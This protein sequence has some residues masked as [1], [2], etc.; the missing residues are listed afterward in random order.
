MLIFIYSDFSS[1]FEEIIDSI[2][3]NHCV[4]TTKDPA[5]ANIALILMER[6]IKKITEFLDRYPDLSILTTMIPH[7]FEDKRVYFLNSRMRD[8]HVNCFV[9]YLWQLKNK[10]SHINMKLCYSKLNLKTEVMEAISVVSMLV[11]IDSINFSISFNK[12]AVYVSGYDTKRNIT[13]SC[14]VNNGGNDFYEEMEVITIYGE[15]YKLTG[16]DELGPHSYGERYCA[17]W[18]T[19]LNEVFQKNGYYQENNDLIILKVKGSFRNF[20]EGRR[21]LS[22]PENGRRGLGGSSGDRYGIS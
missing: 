8:L 10:I 1:I 15:R 14:Y 17:S 13:V 4:K 16:S 20:T 19:T 2:K 21:P 5:Q 22:G 3:S 6:P 12:N 18:Q 7:D 11:D 9:N